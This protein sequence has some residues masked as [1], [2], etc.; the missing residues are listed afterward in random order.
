MPQ[1]LSVRQ[2]ISFEIVGW[3]KLISHLIFFEKL[4]E[5]IVTQ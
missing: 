1:T 5:Y 4:L 2:M 3:E